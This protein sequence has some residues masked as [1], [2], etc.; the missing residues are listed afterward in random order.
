MVFFSVEP[1]QRL[2]FHIDARYCTALEIRFQGCKMDGV[3]AAGQAHG[4]NVIR[5]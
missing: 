3:G 5:S 2:I 1:A 4:D